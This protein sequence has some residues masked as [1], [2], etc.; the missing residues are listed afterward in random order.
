MPRAERTQRVLVEVRDVLAGEADGAGGRLDAAA[1]ACGRASTFPNPIRRRCRPTSPSS[2]S[3]SSAAQDLDQRA[4]PEQGLALR[5]GKRDAQAC[6]GEERLGHGRP[7]GPFSRRRRRSL[8]RSCATSRCRP[9]RRRRFP[10]VASVTLAGTGSSELLRPVVAR[11]R[12]EQRGA[13]GMARARRRG[14]ATSL[15]STTR[16][17][18]ALSRSGRS[19][20]RPRGRGVTNRRRR[21][22]ARLH[23]RDEPQDLLLHRHVERRRRLVRD[24]ELRLAGKAAAISTRWRIPPESSCG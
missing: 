6:D 4:A 14:S 9:R 13:V 23:L 19:W 12:G 21:A 7:H 20:R 22:V 15:S 2:M 8:V 1:P 17:P 11:R 10:P 16:P 5:I 18:R 24:D 3:K